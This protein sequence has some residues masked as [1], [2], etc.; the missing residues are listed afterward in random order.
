MTPSEPA[1]SL[2]DGE[3]L[4]KVL[5]SAGLGSRRTCED[6]IAAGRVTVNGEIAVLG[7]RIDPERDLVEVD[8]VAVGVRP[9]LVHYLLNK[10]AGV[11]TTADDPL[12]RPTVVEL[13]PAEPR[14]FPVGRL[15]LDTEGLLLLTNDGELTHRLTHPSFG[16]D[17]EY[18]AHVEGRPSR[19]QVRR[20]REGIELDDG[21]TAP[22]QAS[23]VSP[24]VLRLV[25]HEGRNRQVRRM[26]EAIGH[27]VQRLVRTR[28][29]PLSDRRLAPGA[30]RPLTSDE[31]RA[32]ERAAGPGPGDR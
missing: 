30:W 20:L 28:I 6:L 16:V 4:Q 1:S 21:P 12:G 24:S 19:G 3:R 25:I 29:G 18:V 32:L 17:K 27:P 9:G 5:A 14:V 11:V 8:G 31:V 22:A 15:D 2:P 23:L 7:R 26:C 10:P 13:V